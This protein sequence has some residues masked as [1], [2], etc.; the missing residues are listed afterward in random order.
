MCNRFAVCGKKH[1]PRWRTSKKLRN[2][3]G[4]FDKDRR[5]Y[6]YFI[7]S[8]MIY[9]VS[10]IGINTIWSWAKSLE[11]VLE[12]EN[13]SAESI[14]TITWQDEVRNMLKNAGIDVE[15]ASKLI[16]CESSWNPDAFH[17]NRNSIDRGLWQLNSYFY[18][19]DKECAYD[20]ICSTK[21]AIEIIKSKG[22]GE[23]V[24]SSKI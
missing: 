19:V 4:R 8:F 9:A 11:K 22:F 16:Q 15:Y 13:T 14:I 2:S 3:R 5:V 24:C 23:W 6:K 10:M 18:P 1:L 21:V 20:P 12:V 7:M 17:Y